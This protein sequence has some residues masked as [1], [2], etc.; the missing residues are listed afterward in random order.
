MKECMEDR[1]DIFY[2]RVLNVLACFAVVML[3]CNGIFWSRPT[4]RLWVTS[5]FIE[6]TMYWAV[7][8]FF[9]NAGVTNMEYRQKYT[10]GEFLV[11]RF[12][13]VGIP[14][15]FW[16]LFSLMLS[17]VS[18]G[19]RINASNIYASI[20]NSAYLSIYWFFV[21]LFAV[22]LSMPLLTVV[23]PEKRKHV[24]GYLISYA[25][26]TISVFPLLCNLLH[27]KYN[28]AIQP[29][30]AAAFMLY[31]LLGYW[32]HHYPLSKRCRYAIY[33]AGIAGWLLH[34]GGTLL[35]SG[36]QEGIP[37]TFKG[38]TNI[39]CVLYS[40]AVFTLF[41]YMDFRW[42][43]QK[44]RWLCRAIYSFG[45]LTFG[46]YLIHYYLMKG[47]LNWF[48]ISNDSIYWRVFGSF[49]IFGISAGIVWLL[50]KLPVVKKIVP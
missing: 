7:P 6:V 25:V 39:P 46:I 40:T 4:G 24:F 9:M 20:A 18:D 10:T 35:L 33:M 41:C 3:H 1:E 36:M 47:M 49:L 23:L 28:A 13:K 2:I 22:Y 17:A 12:Q 11:R 37:M 30:V 29:P 5:N 27:L 48:G 21:P 44:C 32:I 45:K 14:F 8:V 15:V 43:K 26:L 16:S 38:Y 19:T 50:K 34:F 31:V 42:L